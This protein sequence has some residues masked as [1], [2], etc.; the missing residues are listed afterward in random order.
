MSTA[1][2]ASHLPRRATGRAAHASASTSWSV[3]KAPVAFFDHTSLPSFRISNT[4]PEDL[5]RITVAP[6]FFASS[7]SLARRARGS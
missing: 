3:G 5:V 6:G 4:P 7:R 2:P 1:R